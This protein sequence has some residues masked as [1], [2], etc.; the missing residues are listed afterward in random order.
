MTV[1]TGIECINLKKAQ[2]NRNMKLAKASAVPAE[3]TY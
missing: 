2:Y 3:N 1:G